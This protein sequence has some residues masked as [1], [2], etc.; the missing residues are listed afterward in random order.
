MSFINEGFGLASRRVSEDKR[1]VCGQEATNLL[2]FKAFLPKELT[3]Q[4]YRICSKRPL[5]KELQLQR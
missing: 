5:R 4:S 1:V 3:F 2:K